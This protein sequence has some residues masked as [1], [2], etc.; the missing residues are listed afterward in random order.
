M[1]NVVAVGVMT[2]LYLSS[3]T[4]AGELYNY[5]AIAY[6][7]A[8]RTDEL[9]TVTATVENFVIGTQTSG[10]RMHDKNVVKSFDEHD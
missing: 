4:D 7:D 5:S 8:D 2:T 1:N 3:V 10:R 9:F 6:L